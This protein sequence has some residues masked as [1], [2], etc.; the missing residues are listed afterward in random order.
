MIVWFY[1]FAYNFFCSIIL[2]YTVLGS[3]VM[4]LCMCSVHVLCCHLAYHN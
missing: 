3:I 2:Y 4:H 1:E